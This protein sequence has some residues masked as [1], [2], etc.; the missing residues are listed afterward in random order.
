M[1][2]Y[3]RA[4]SR[5]ERQLKRDY[6]KYFK[7]VEKIGDI[8]CNDID[9][10]IGTTL[11]IGSLIWVAGMIALPSIMSKGIIPLELIQPLYLGLPI[12]GGLVAEEGLFKSFKNKERLKKASK[13][14]NQQERIEHA[15]N[16]K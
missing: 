8:K 13:A 10:R 3:E 6:E 5:I 4:K 9:V 14:K 1:I 12:L 16:M 2:D 7:L 11:G 15:T